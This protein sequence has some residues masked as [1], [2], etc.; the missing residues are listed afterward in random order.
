MTARL[1]IEGEIMKDYA[2]MAGSHPAANKST[3]KQ[4]SNHASPA[5]P[6]V[7]KTLPPFLI[8]LLLEKENP[9]K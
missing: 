5:N 8:P 4:I 7:L 2:E 3:A 1:Q 6:A 9:K